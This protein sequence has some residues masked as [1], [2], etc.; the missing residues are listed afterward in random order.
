ML[1]P[2]FWSVEY[3]DPPSSTPEPDDQEQSSTSLEAA[4]LENELQRHVRPPQ[5]YPQ[6]SNSRPKLQRQSTITH[7][8]EVRQVTSATNNDHIDQDNDYKKNTS[9]DISYLVDNLPT[10][11]NSD[12]AQDEH[13]SQQPRPMDRPRRSNPMLNL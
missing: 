8:S 2:L 12:T 1:S 4:D 13:S 7:D 6:Q 10:Q 3:P 11:C 5:N 9:E